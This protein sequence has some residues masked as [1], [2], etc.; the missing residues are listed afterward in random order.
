MYLKVVE[1][2]IWQILFKFLLEEK[3]LKMV[4]YAH[5]FQFPLHSFLNP[6]TPHYHPLPKPPLQ[7]IN[8]L[9]KLNHFLRVLE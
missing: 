5:N 6:T 8:S 4:L 7:A 1:E 3:D 9:V 2:L